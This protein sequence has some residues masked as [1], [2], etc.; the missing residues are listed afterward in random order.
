MWVRLTRGGYRIVCDVAPDDDHL[1]ALREHVVVTGERVDVDAP[2]VC[3][4]NV[5]K[6]LIDYCFGP[7]GGKRREI[8]GR[9]VTALKRI[10]MELNFIDTHPA[11]IERGVLGWHGI[12]IPAWGDSTPYSP[13]PMPG[14]FRELTPVWDKTRKGERLTRWLPLNGDPVHEHVH[15]LLSTH[16]V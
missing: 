16:P 4:F 11:L 8:P 7:L 10:T 6:R 3:W 15:L 9:A 12:V 1:D 14:M 2:Y 13:Q 5:Q